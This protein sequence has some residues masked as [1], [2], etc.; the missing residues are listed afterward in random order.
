[1]KNI[2]LKILAFINGIAFIYCASCL[3]SINY[4]PFYIGCIVSLAYLT[5]FA[6]ANGYVGGK[7]AK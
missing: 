7:S 1:M 6:Y 3:D 2:I 4:T 5:L